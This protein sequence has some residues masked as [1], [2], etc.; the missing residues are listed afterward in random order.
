MALPYN[1]FSSWRHLKKYCYRSDLY[2]PACG[3]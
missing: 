1:G 2:G 3:S